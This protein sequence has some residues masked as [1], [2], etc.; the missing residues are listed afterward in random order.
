[1][2]FSPN[3]NCGAGVMN[4]VPTACAYD[5]IPPNLPYYAQVVTPA[6]ASGG[7]CAPG[8]GAPN[9]TAVPTGLVTLC[10]Q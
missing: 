7:S 2:T 5:G 4:P 6:K 8:G 10:C 1:V 3:A 9:G